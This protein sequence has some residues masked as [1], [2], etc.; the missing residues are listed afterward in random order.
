MRK[1]KIVCTLG[2]ATDGGVLR[3]LLLSGMNVARLNF[4]HG[5]HDE[6]LKRVESFKK[7]RTDLNL[8]AALLLDV[9]G[10]KIRL[11]KFEN[12]TE[13]LV[14]GA[15]FTLTVRDIVGSD[16]IASV[17]YKELHHD[18]N[19]GDR[20]LIA[21]G[22]IE[23][24]IQ[25]IHDT[26]IICIVVNGGPIG[27]NKS[28]NVP[29][30]RI[31]LPFISDRDERDLLFAIQHDFDFIAASFARSSDDVKEIRTF[32]RTHGG[33]NIKI[34]SKIENRDGVNNIDGIIRASDGIMVARGDMGVEIPF[35]ELP[36]IQKN[37]IKQCNAAGI[38][39]ITATQML[40]SMV[41][42]PRP[43]RAEITDVANA[44]YD[45]TCAI[46]LSGETSIGK[47]PVAAVNTMSAIAMETEKTI[48][49]IHRFEVTH[50]SISQNVTN[51]ISHATCATA[52]SLEASAIITV[53]QSGHTARMVSKYRPGCP[54]I[55]TTI[56]EKSCRQLSLI[57]GVFPVL[58]EKKSSTDDI[59]K[60]AIEK[61]IW[62]SLINDGDLVVITG[63][64]LANVSGSTNTIRVYMVGDVLIKGKSGN[65]Y[66]G[67]GIVRVLDQA[68]IASADFHT[69][70][71]AVIMNTSDEML[72]LLKQAGGI[73]SEDTDSD[74]KAVTVG[75]IL[76][77]PVIT[78]AANATKILKS[79][80]VVTVNA[81]EGKVYSGSR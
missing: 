43:T 27:N 19:I 63:G 78:H 45:G 64:M 60:Q 5:S 77:V 44:I 42:N 47:Y 38:P 34:I 57:W 69:G 46:M 37:I 75:K 76:G 35:V 58:V 48:D 62:T 3:E 50:L 12:D 74:S 67:K 15:T 7:L 24:R 40:E 65:D 51:A 31:N 8:P 61:S 13:T 25:S 68:G 17:S 2:P 49:Y 6:H 22:L 54:I 80:I 14:N 26:D 20:L 52:H 56:S 79:G 73:I 1:T 30:V 55:A 28:I 81:K 10:P 53:T 70:D 32:L 29:G 41:S 39:V 18:V 11:G 66:S 71:I 72:P 59:F 4:S 33:D 23:L 9:M 21:D 16:S 36:Y